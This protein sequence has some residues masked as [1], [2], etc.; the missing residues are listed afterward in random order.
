ML[1]ASLGVTFPQTVTLTFTGRDAVNNYVQLDSV[2]VVNMTRSWQEILYWPDTVL[3]M[4]VSVGIDENDGPYHGESMQLFQN[5]P[6][7]FNGVTDVTLYV[8]DAGAVALE[9]TDVNGRFVET[10]HATFLQNGCQKFRINVANAGIYALTARQNGKSSSIK[11][12]NNG[13]G[14]GNGIEYMG[15]VGNETT[16][17][18]TGHAASPQNRQNK[19]NGYR[20]TTTNPFKFG[21][22]MEYVGYAKINDNVEES[23]RITQQQGTAQT[24]KLQFDVAQT[25]LP[26]VT[27]YPVSGVTQT[28]AVVGGEVVA[29]GY[30][31]VFDRGVCWN[32]TGAPTIADN[33]MHIGSGMGAFTDTLTGLQPGTTYHVRSYAINNVGTAYGNEVSFTTLPKDGNPC[34]GVSII[35]DVEN[36][37]YNTVQVGLQCWMKEN[38]RTTK[39]ADGTTIPH[40]ST[41]SYDDPYWYYPNNDSTNK[42]TYGLLYNWVSVMGKSFSSDLNPS[43]VQGICPNGWHVPSDAEWTQLTDYV[44]SQNQYVCVNTS[45]YIAKALAANTGWSNDNGVCV[46]G[47]DLTMNNATGF[48]V[49]PAGYFFAAYAYFGTY[50]EFWS[51]TE[52]DNTGAY[53]VYMYHNYAYVKR[54]IGTKFG[55]YSV[56]CLKD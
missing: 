15:T 56:R 28:V 9:L 53:C 36:N 6:N 51:S 32:T 40:G 46:V 1:L 48:G 39:Y 8:A 5:N 27:T 52:S 49:L 14:N 50:A 30:T 55:A 2:S 18:K 38:L 10:W 41:Y 43:G 19:N 3:K 44:S 12:V 21:D 29:D 34:L 16:I 42:P 24:F 17:V 11:M 47:N 4:Q 20:G 22:M 31:P 26:T 33:Y 54:T 45:T 7:P 25:Y 23:Q 35:T 13:G 37:K